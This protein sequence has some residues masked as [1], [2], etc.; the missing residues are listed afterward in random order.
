MCSSD[1]ITL[2]LPQLAF[3]SP[4]NVL[5]LVLAGALLGGL[6]GWLARAKA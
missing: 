4:V 1:L 5:A 6:G 3:L 2:D